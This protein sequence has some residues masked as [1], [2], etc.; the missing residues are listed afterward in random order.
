MISSTP[1]VADPPLT[2]KL[3]SCPNAKLNGG[4]G[5]YPGGVP[6]TMRQFL[7]VPYA[8]APTGAR[9]WKPPQPFCWTGK[10]DAYSFGASCP[11]SGNVF[12]AANEDCLFLNIFTEAAG[13][14]RRRP[15]MVYIHGGSFTSGSGFGY[16]PVKLVNRGV[17][18][19]TI[20]YRLGAL[21]LLAHKALDNV[22][23]KR[24][25]HYG[26]LDQLAA[27]QWV[28]DN[29]AAF[30]GNPNNVTVFGQS[31]GG[32]GI[33]AL[34]VTPLS[35]GLFQRAIIESGPV[36][37]SISLADAEKAGATFAANTGCS[38]G[39]N[40]QKAAC[41]RALS[42]ADVVANQGVLPVSSYFKTDGV[43]FPDT[44]RNRL[45]AG[46]FQDVP[47]INGTTHNERR[48][49]FGTPTVLTFSCPRVSNLVPDG[50]GNFA[51][52]VTY[53][54][55]LKAFYPG[56]WRAV[57]KR[58][59]GTGSDLKA[60]G[61]FA[62]AKTDSIFSCSVWR[63]SNRIAANGGKVYAYEFNDPD[64]PVTPAKPPITLHD[65]TDFPQGPQHTA[66][67]QYIFPRRTTESVCGVP[68]AGLSADQQTLSDAMVIYWTTFAKTGNPNP[69]KGTRPP[70]W[71]RYT[72]PTGPMMSLV[73][74]TPQRMGAKAFNRDHKC[75]AFWDPM[76]PE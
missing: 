51:G 5:D 48:D 6:G 47:I 50:Q 37:P 23:Q 9:R 12:P 71:P 61:A 40:K 32:I 73:S 52:A 34:L 68:Y 56:S 28:K 64:A 30:G 1:A 21:G 14:V 39:T 15:V 2:V 44:I 54:K 41:L 65:G 7:G 69:R 8:A 4:A 74:A 59:R 35:A 27:L 16:N 22:A 43:I 13:T 29:I 25:G 3:R 42:V 72:G 18:V 55:A 17:I 60:N 62:S 31:A 76:E 70:K 58:Y 24:S 75:G 45:I 53:T 49:L 19:V 66:E 63:V 10:R 38:T 11:Q 46:Q 36:N 57:R 67:L 20:N 26:T 33:V